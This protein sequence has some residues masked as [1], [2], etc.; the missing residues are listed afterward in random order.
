MSRLL[1]L[2]RWQISSNRFDAGF[3][4]STCFVGAIAVLIFGFSAISRFATTEYE[5]VIGLVSVS[6]LAM[7]AVVIGMILPIVVEN[8]SS[9]KRT[10]EK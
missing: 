10:G 9:R 5:I 3:G 7:Q 6:C 2:F 1:N 4:Q 8:E